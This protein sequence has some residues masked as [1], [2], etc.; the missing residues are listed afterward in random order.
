MPIHMWYVS[1]DLVGLSLFDESTVVVE[2]W[3]IA[4]TMQ[5]RAGG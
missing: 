4:S 2:K 3:A 1:E 5:Q